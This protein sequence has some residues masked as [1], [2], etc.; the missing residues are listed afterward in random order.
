MLQTTEEVK[1]NP[2]YNRYVNG[3][4]LLGY[5]PVESHDVCW[6][7]LRQENAEDKF[8][9]AAFAVPPNRVVEVYSA[10]SKSMVKMAQHEFV[11][12]TEKSVLEGK[13][14]VAAKEMASHIENN[15]FVLVFRGGN[16]DKGMRFKNREEANEW[17]N[18]FTYFD[19]VMD[20]K[21][22]QD[23]C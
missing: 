14:K 19:E 15:P 21:D 5:I 2:Y 11:F 10:A 12:E 13:D 7:A 1:V 17:L 20:E 9:I 3:S 6:Y 16:R 4:E 22:L 18:L 23:N 8:V